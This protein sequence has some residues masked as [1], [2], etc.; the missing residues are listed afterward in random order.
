MEKQYTVYAVVGDIGGTKE[1]KPAIEALQKIIPD[2]QVKWFVDPSPRAA[3]GTNVLDPA[4]IKYERRMPSP[5][6]RTDLLV[7]GASATAYEAQ[8]EWTKW[9]KALNVPV[10]GVNDFYGTI[11]LPQVQSVSPD[12]MCVLDEQD[13]DITRAVR[14][15]VR[16][17]VC[18]KPSFA[19]DIGPLL[20]RK[21]EIR[22]EVR[23]RLGIAD[24]EIMVLVSP[25][26]EVASFSAHLDAVKQVAEKLQGK[27]LVFVPRAH[28]KFLASPEGSQ[29]S[30]Q[31]IAELVATGAGVIADSAQVEKNLVQVVL[32]SDLM[33]C[34]WGSTDQ[35][36]AAL[37]GIP[38]VLFLFPDDLAKR[39]VTGYIDGVPPLIRANAGWAAETPERL[40]ERVDRVL[41]DP[42]SAGEFVK[43]GATVFQPLIRLGAAGRIAQVMIDRLFG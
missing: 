20:A 34:T 8:V 37:A 33:I 21:N 30:E 24:D 31:K 3:G 1:V 6:D 14:P 38:V 12:I 5:D 28:P 35:F 10:V 18:G 26:S 42:V 40:M 16:T 17:V 36:T 15:G 43:T 41:S 19:Q 22:A 2:V 39:K 7:Y 32:A 23:G 13:A 4:G 29:C 27:K 11:N 25:G 9:A